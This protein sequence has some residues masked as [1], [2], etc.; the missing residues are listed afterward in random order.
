MKKKS[1]ESIKKSQKTNDNDT[2]IT[3]DELANGVMNTFDY[4]YNHLK[5]CILLHDLLIHYI[6]FY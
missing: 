5:S 1:S 6:P 4:S 2:Y 3:Q